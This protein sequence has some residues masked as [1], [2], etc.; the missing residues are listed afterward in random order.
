V[1]LAHPDPALHDGTIALRRWERSDLGCV[2]AAAS[3]P[4]MVQTT[5]VPAVFTFEAGHAYIER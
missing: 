3:D 5:T 1:A 4:R 2:R